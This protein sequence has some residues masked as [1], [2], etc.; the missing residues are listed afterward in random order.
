MVRETHLKTDDMILP[1]FVVLGM[2]DDPAYK[3]YILWPLVVA[4]AFPVAMFTVLQPAI[5]ADIMDHDTGLTGYQREAM[6]NGMQGL[7]QKVGWGLAPLMQGLLFSVFGNTVDRPWGIL[8]A[9]LAA[10]VL[11]LAG[12]IWFLKYPLRK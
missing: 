7:I 12:A 6:Y 11:C 5:L 9:G 10:A 1:L 3:Q 2:V 4:V 8:L